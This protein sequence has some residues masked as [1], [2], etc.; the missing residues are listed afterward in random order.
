MSI[1]SATEG[2]MEP[3]ATMVITHRV[4]A[5]EHAEY[6]RWLDEIEPLCRAW[7]GHLDWHILRPVKGLPETF[8]VVIRFDTR[9]HLQQWMESS[10]RARL[11]DKVRPLFVTPDDVHVSSGL[12]FWFVSAESNAKVPVRWK[13]YLMTWS[14]IYPLVLGLPLALTPVVGRLGLPDT[15][16]LHTLVNT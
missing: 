15:L 14:A 16:P 1:R 13:Q 8:T 10:Q 6:E 7:P 5:E 12:D 9:A 4:R 3:G 2:A 11:L